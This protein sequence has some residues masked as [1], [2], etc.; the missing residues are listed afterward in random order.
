VALRLNHGQT[1]DICAAHGSFPKENDNRGKRRHKLETPAPKWGGA[2]N[3]QEESTPS[4]LVRSTWTERG[5]NLVLTYYVVLNGGELVRKRL[6]K[7]KK[8]DGVLSRQEKKKSVGGG[9][10]VRRHQQASYI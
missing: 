5:Q 3:C 1:K 6:M 9:T 10:H 7:K 8:K 4:L 2:V